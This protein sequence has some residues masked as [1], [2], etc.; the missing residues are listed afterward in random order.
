MF[1]DIPVKKTV[2]EFPRNI[3][4]LSI[5]D[6]EDYIK[7]LQ[8]EIARVELDIQKKTAS[9]GTADSFFK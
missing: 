1:D 7:S 4:T 9:Q 6:L 2:D 8:A 5:A 3:E